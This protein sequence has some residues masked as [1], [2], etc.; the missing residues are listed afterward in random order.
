MR[1]THFGLV[2][3][4]ISVACGCVAPTAVSPP[5]ASSIVAPTATASPLIPEPPRK[6]ALL[7]RD[8]LVLLGAKSYQE[9]CAAC[10]QNNGRGVSS[11]N[12]TSLHQSTAANDTNERFLRFVMFNEPKKQHAAWYLAMSPAALASALTYVRLQFPNSNQALIQPSEVIAELAKLSA[13]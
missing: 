4:V 10:H 13:K 6:V 12:I 8:A 5:S 7:T 9:F 2:L 3:V 1:I 11:A